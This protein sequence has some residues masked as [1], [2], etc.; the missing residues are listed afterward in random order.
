MNI[1]QKGKVSNT[2]AWEPIGGQVGKNEW[3]QQAWGTHITQKP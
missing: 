3:S 1:S 2:G